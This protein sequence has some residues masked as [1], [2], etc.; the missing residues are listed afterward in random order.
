MELYP[1]PQKKKT[2]SMTVH[3]T[4]FDERSFQC[5]WYMTFLFIDSC[6]WTSNFMGSL[7]I[8]RPNCS[9]CTLVVYVAYI[10]FM[11]Q[12]LGPSG[13][14]NKPGAVINLINRE[15]E[16]PVDI[17]LKK[18]GTCLKISD[19]QL[20]RPELVASQ[21]GELQRTAGF[22]SLPRSGGAA[23]VLLRQVGHQ[24]V[25][26]QASVLLRSRGQ[27]KTYFFLVN[28]NATKVVMFKLLSKSLNM[29]YKLKITSYLHS[30][31][32]F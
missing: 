2:H 10:H 4:S 24:R 19:R 5:L 16:L 7:Q 30:K 14:L 20:D 23:A 6:S 18:L 11:T 22:D 17:S 9:F 26:R 29:S 25:R 32:R 28:Q 12:L 27:N 31:L 13:Y 15:C 21:E 1:P 3:R 8:F